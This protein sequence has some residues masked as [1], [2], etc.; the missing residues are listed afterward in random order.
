MAVRAMCWWLLFLGQSHGGS[1][2]TPLS[3]EP[4][5]GPSTVGLRESKE[6]P[7]AQEALLVQDPETTG[8]APAVAPTQV[9]VMPPRLPKPPNL[10]PPS[11]CRE[12]GPPG[13][14]LGSWDQG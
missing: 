3:P 13:S 1:A 5:G 12:H 6:V 2:V 14:A 8:P 4:V 10:E 7:R 11:L 9:L